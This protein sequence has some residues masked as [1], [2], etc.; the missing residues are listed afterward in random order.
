MT[1]NEAKLCPAFPRDE[2][3]VSGARLPALVT[4]T[5]SARSSARFRGQRHRAPPDAEKSVVLDDPYGWQ[6]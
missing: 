6:R 4:V 2:G 3:D 1:D 5:L